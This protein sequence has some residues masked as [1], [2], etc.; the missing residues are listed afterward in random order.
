MAA[1]LTHA[2]EA[3]GPQ[4]LKAATIQNIRFGADQ[5]DRSRV[6]NKAN[7]GGS[8]RA[9]EIEHARGCR[10]PAGRAARVGCG[11]STVQMPAG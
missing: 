5:T 1:H 8:V 10:G 11:P 2:R 4:E 6:G 7:N 3:L 9:I